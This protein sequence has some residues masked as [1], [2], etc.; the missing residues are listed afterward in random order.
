MLDPFCG[1][2]T[3]CVVAEKLGCQWIG[4]DISKQA[5]T[6]LQTRLVLIENELPDIKENKK[7]HKKELFFR[8]D[9]PQRQDLGKLKKYNHPDNKNKLI[10]KQKSCCNGCK[11]EFLI[12][13]LEIDHITPRKV[14]GGDNIENLQLL[15]RPCN[16]L[17]GS[18][19]MEYLLKKL[20]SDSNYKEVL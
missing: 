12:S 13:F 18:H 3:T 1:C 5:Y 15:C 14:G 4:I 16:S 19:T 20:N 11:K 17:K 7:K 10:I 6:L 2:A 9:I 8:K